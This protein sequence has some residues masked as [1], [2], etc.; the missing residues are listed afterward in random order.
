MAAS[1]ERRAIL[2]SRFTSCIYRIKYAWSAVADEFGELTS[3]Q[4]LT[5]VQATTLVQSHQ[6]SA[7]AWMMVLLSRAHPVSFQD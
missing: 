1:M 7:L 4:V 6:E 5:E 3:H 2:S